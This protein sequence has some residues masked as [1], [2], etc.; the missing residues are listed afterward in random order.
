MVGGRWWSGLGLVAVQEDEEA[1]LQG[2][3]ERKADAKSLH[4]GKVLVVGYSQIKFLDRTFCVKDRKCRTRMC[5]PGTRTENVI[6]RLEA[7]MTS[8]LFA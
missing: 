1:G 6:D 4:E 5:F 2:A 3:K 7:C 8:P